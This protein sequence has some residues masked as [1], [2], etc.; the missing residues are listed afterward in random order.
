MILYTFIRHYHKHSESIGRICMHPIHLLVICALVYVL[1][2]VKAST[3]YGY[4][5]INIYVPIPPLF[6]P[7]RLIVAFQTDPN[8]IVMCKLHYILFLLVYR[9]LV[10]WKDRKTN[11]MLYDVPTYPYR[12]RGHIPIHCPP[13]GVVPVNWQRSNTTYNMIV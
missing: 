13:S 3:S 5:Q 4:R 6:I 12:Y 8:T 11:G 2:Y 1:L 10:A 7:L 9:R